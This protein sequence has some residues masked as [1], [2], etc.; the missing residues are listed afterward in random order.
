MEDNQNTHNPHSTSDFYVV[1]SRILREPSHVLNEPTICPTG[2]TKQQGGSK[3]TVVSTK[4]S[5]E[6]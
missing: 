3:I 5:C 4:C 2:Q 1:S 6:H